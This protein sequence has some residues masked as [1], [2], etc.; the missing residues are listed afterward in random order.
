MAY[1]YTG[2][3]P[4]APTAASTD[5]Q[6][7]RW[8]QYQDMLARAAASKLAEQQL[9]IATDAQVTAAAQVLATEAAAKGAQAQ[10]DAV[11]A[12]V[13]L[14]REALAAL[15]VPSASEPSLSE[16]MWQ[17]IDAYMKRHAPP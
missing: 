12:Q 17:V 14:L 3:A 15:K 4:T 11:Q 10:A 13:P 9:T 7:T 6:W 16:L 5:A 8:L 2:L 1:D